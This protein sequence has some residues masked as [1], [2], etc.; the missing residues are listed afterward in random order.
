VSIIREIPVFIADYGMGE[1]ADLNQR[2]RFQAA[3]LRVD[4]L[5]PEGSDLR[6]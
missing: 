3:K 4:G 5:D 2:R 1:S 6:P